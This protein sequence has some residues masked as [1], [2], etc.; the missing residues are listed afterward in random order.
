M[1]MLNSINGGYSPANAG[2]AYGKEKTEKVE[3]SGK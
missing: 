1:S 2:K 3:D